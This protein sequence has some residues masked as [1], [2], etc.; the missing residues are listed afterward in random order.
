LIKLN[1]FFGEMKG[2]NLL[3]FFKT[4]VQ[5]FNFSFYPVNRFQS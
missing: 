4:D 3:L 2:L 1:S 5:F